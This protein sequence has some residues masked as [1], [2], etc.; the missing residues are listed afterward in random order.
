MKQM[1][2]MLKIG[3]AAVCLVSLLTPGFRSA[4][5]EEA[6]QE[7]KGYTIDLS[8]GY[9]HNP[10]TYFN[11]MFSN[12][13]A[14]AGWLGIKERV[15]EQYYDHDFDLDGDGTF[16]VGIRSFNVR[17]Y[18]DSDFIFVPLAGGS[19]NG[20]VTLPAK[21]EAP[22]ASLT[23]VLNNKQVKKEYRITLNGGSAAVDTGEENPE[24]YERIY[25]KVTTAAPGTRIYL[26]VTPKNGKYVASWDAKGFTFPAPSSL[27]I[28]LITSIVMPA[29]DVSITPVLADQVPVTIEAD[30]LEGYVIPEFEK[31]GEYEVPCDLERCIFESLQ[32][33]KGKMSEAFGTY[34]DLDGDGTWDVYIGPHK[35]SS[36]LFGLAFR[37]VGPEFTMTG[38]NTGMYYPITI[39]FK[40]GAE[41]YS[42]NLESGR[43]YDP[44]RGDYTTE[45]LQKYLKPFELKDKP[46]YFDPDKDGKA[47]LRILPDGSEL[48]VLATYSLGETYSVP[49]N[50]DTL[51]QPLILVCKT[52]PAFC[53]VDIDCGEGGSVRLYEAEKMRGYVYEDSFNVVVSTDLSEAVITYQGESVT[54]RECD[55]SRF[56]PETSLYLQP[57]PEQ[58]YRLKEV[59]YQDGPEFTSGQWFR[60]GKK[61]VRI[62]VIFEKMAEP[63]PVITES[64]E[65]PTETP[66]AEPTAVPSK[67]GKG[68]DKTPFKPIYVILPVGACVAACIA[69]IAVYQKKRRRNG[70]DTTKKE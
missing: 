5:A 47:D 41:A 32:N 11:G 9:Y 58:G 45:T 69:S 29:H 49:A 28:R 64:P 36:E 46:G 38:T 27:G 26:Q 59:V 4:R 23:F 39:R 31:V 25:K 70:P 19:V 57:I 12:Q 51:Q 53:Q 65:N 33:S 30:N 67:D 34:T 2:K 14:I 37:S 6:Q 66:S 44:Y 62:S 18:G 7:R 63:T 22:F 68:K 40:D 54:Y 3:I 35:S 10:D 56:L 16:D 55:G 52:K 21:E 1:K 50:A 61:D 20:K 15:D 13:E 60:L 43:I 17:A 8:A 48:Q 24:T 42:V